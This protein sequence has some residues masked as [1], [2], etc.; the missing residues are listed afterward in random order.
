MGTFPGAPSEI[1]VRYQTG[2][3]RRFWRGLRAG[4]CSPLVLGLVIATL[5]TGTAGA[6]GTQMFTT[7]AASTGE[8]PQSKIWYHDG[9]YWAVLQGSSGLAFY[10]KVG[11]AW[12]L[13]T[14][15]NAVLTSSGNA[16]VKWNG[17]EL[18]VLNY[19]ATPRLFKYTYA[20]TTR[21]WVLVSGF[22]VSLPNPTDSETMV[23]EQDSTGR[24]WTTAEGGGNIN[25]YY[26]TSADHRTWVTTPVVLRTGVNIDDISSIVAFGG[27]KVGVFWSDQ[28]R[29]EFGFRFHNDTDAP[30]TWSTTEVIVSGTG[31]S[32]DHINLAFDSTGRVYAITKDASDLM[33][34]HRRATTGVWTT[35][36][37][38]FGG[39]GTRGV[40]MVAEADAK[41]Y[42]LYTRWDVTPFRI[43]Y[44]VGD[45]NTLTFGANVNF[46]STSSEM[47][48]VTGMKQLLPAGSLVA[49]AEN[50]THCWYNSFGSPPTTGP[51]PPQNLTANL[52]SAPERVALAW[53]QPATGAPGGY[54]VY[55]QVDGGSL[56]QLNAALLTSTTYTD[57]SPPRSPLCY[58]V[59]AVTAGTEGAPSASACVDNS[60]LPPPGPPQALNVVLADIPAVPAAVQFEFDAG[61]GQTVQDV[62]GN[63]NHARLGSATGA[64][65]SDPAWVAGV[66]GSALQFD[67]T[68]DYIEVAD[69]PSLDFP[70]SFTVE[71]WVRYDLGAATGTWANKGDSGERT[72]RIRFTSARD[73]EFRWDTTTGTAREVLATDALPDAAWHHVA[74]VYDQAAGQ[75]RVYVDGALQASAAAT[76]IPATNAKALHLGVRFTSSFSNYLDGALDAFR[77]APQAVYSGSFAKPRLAGPRLATGGGG[78]GITAQR[79]E[80]TWQAPAPGPAVG[81]YNVY[82]ST[83]GAFTRLN[84]A[85]LT[86]LSFLDGPLGVGSYCYYVTAINTQDLEGAASSTG[87]AD[88]LPPL[89]EAPGNL[90]AQLVLSPGAALPGAVAYPFDEGSGHT[91]ESALTAS[92]PGTRGSG[93]GNDTADPLWNGGLFGGCL[94][95]DGA[96]DRAWTANAAD[97][98]FQSSFTLEAW[99]VHAGAGAAQTIVSKG[100][101]AS[102]NYALGLDSTG[103]LRLHWRDAQG[104]EYGVTSADPVPADAWHHVAGVFDSAAA[105]CRVYVN[106][107]AAGTAPA[108]GVPQTNTSALLLGAAQAPSG[109]TQ[110]F[111]GSLDLVRA[112]A[113]VLYTGTFT[114]PQSFDA[115]PVRRVD[116]AWTASPGNL[117]AGYDVYRQVQNGVPERL[118][119]AH[120]GGL[121]FTDPTPSDGAACYSV[122]AIDT[123]GRESAASNAACVQQAATDAGAMPRPPGLFVRAVPNPF[124]PATALWFDLAQTSHVELTLFDARGRQVTTLVRGTL[125]A[126]PHRIVWQGGDGA[127]GIAPSGVYFAVLR[128]GANVARTRLILLK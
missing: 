106:G 71:G 50:G 34:V 58:L 112:C 36:T 107:V 120:L 24:L 15:A 81:G 56:V 43:E 103:R 18:F 125:G 102:L 87:C 37:N 110:Y 23:L 2:S 46:I 12:Q 33:R 13:K 1:L 49:I 51:G 25:V 42:I 100:L 67:G 122:V 72:F 40:I 48:N 35:K 126:G 93:P 47:N 128:A 79:A 9:S 82:R 69:S 20:T 75:N 113:G 63:N 30:G 119:A 118:N 105:E 121:V 3:G 95:F 91:F 74:C 10:E 5:G 28:T 26:S 16:D 64:D 116:L 31:I 114:P 52:L 101:D 111:R 21:A 92:H 55:R 57:T 65:T 61:S 4:V 94:R 29:W 45:L 127:G 97:L 19:A 7:V 78:P 32:D 88:V 62:S 86:A 22:P 73:I 54:N 76:G 80:L 117:I 123:L 115:P 70:A 68:N 89:P 84:P 109:Y 66:T 83:G 14:F 96:N 44:R 8:K 27:N 104:A 17:T 124:N 6:A 11:T 53:S 77:I 108:A 39:V 99:I 60:P 38:V 85:P 59:R 98:G 90:S 41:V